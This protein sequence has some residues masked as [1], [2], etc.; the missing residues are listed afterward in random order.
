MPVAHHILYLFSTAMAAAPDR[1]SFLFWTILSS[2]ATTT[3][4]APFALPEPRTLVPRGKFVFNNVT[5]T[6]LIFN[7][8]TMQP[9]PQGLA[10]DGGGTDFSPAALLW[11]AFCFLVG[12]PMALAGIRGWRFTTG[13]GIG[14]AVAVSC[15]IPSV[16]YFA[17]VPSN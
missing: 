15:T 12:V 16:H 17:D 7:P 5:G 9:I 2:F 11:L 3:L 1:L 4:A 13:V 10:T 14:L 8:A 6:P